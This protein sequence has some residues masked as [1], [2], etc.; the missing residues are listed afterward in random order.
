MAK[1]LNIFSM[2]ILMLTLLLIS[3]CGNDS[4]DEVPNVQAT[5]DAAIEIGIAKIPTPTPLPSSTPTPTPTP[6]PLPVPTPTPTPT[7]TPVPW[8]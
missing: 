4:P 6:T 7:P 5:I 1:Q 3:A 2:I 8:C